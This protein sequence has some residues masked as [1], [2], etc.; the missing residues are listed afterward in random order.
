LNADNQSG[1]KGAEAKMIFDEAW[2]H[3]QRQSDR[4]I[5]EEGEDNNGEDSFVELAVAQH[6]GVRHSRQGV[7][8]IFPTIPSGH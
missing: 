4:E 7:Q 3:G 1:D 2:Q 8:E 6:S 5:A